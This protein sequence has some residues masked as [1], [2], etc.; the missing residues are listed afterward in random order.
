LY[1]DK[2]LKKMKK[3]ILPIIA[4]L[5]ST[6]AYAQLGINTTTPK[7]TL[8]ITA[9]NATG[10]STATDGLHKINNI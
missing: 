9:K 6:I 5:F 8:D 7:S 10:S 2:K 3:K 1:E 4:I